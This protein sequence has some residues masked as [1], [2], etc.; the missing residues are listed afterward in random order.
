L[1]IPEIFGKQL[2][3]KLAETDIVS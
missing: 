1:N 2:P 3:N